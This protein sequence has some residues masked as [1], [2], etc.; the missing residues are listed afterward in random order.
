MAGYVVNDLTLFQTPS[1]SIFLPTFVMVALF[2]FAL[3]N[4][5]RMILHAQGRCGQLHVHV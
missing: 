4:W 5:F 2:L 1:A 3:P